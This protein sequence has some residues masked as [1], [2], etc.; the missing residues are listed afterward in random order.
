MAVETTEFSRGEMPSAWLRRMAG[1]LPFPISLCRDLPFAVLV[2][3]P[4]SSN[5]Q[6]SVAPQYAGISASLRRLSAIRR[7][8]FR[9]VI[10]LTSPNPRD[11][12]SLIHDQKIETLAAAKR[13]KSTRCAIHRSALGI[14]RTG[15]YRS[16]GKIS[17][18]N[19]A[20]T[21]ILRRFRCCLAL[22]ANPLFSEGSEEG[23]SVWSPFV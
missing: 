7:R 2:A 10:F 6:T 17:R 8:S 4:V 9:R 16:L 11:F 18:K 23:R 14:G 15:P 13:H 5:F 12:R 21:P 20:L 19:L 1:W 3:R 22:G